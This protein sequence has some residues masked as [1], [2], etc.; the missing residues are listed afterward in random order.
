VVLL[1]NLDIRFLEEVN[2]GMQKIRPLVDRHPECQSV[3]T[4]MLDLYNE[5]ANQAVENEK[6]R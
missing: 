3:V 6:T 2:E 5:I 1:A 4:K